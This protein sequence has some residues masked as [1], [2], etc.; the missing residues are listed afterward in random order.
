MGIEPRPDVCGLMYARLQQR[1]LER[2]RDTG[3]NNVKLGTWLFVA[4]EAM[5]FGGLFSA[6]F[7]LRAGSIT[8]GWSPHRDL[9]LAN[10]VIL[11]GATG[12]FSAAAAAARGRR[13][14][15]F[16]QLTF[17]AVA[18]AAICLGVKADE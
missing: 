17:A 6:Y 13:L 9:A 8:W 14:S 12:C 3:M 4:S 5:L 10:T 7:I 11:F 18:R 16:R 15:I 2:Q 1:R